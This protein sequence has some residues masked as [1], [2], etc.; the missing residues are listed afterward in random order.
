MMVGLS[1][2]IAGPS[3]QP[4]APPAPAF[5]QIAGTAPAT[6][7]TNGLEPLSP[8][9]VIYSP[10]VTSAY[11][12]GPG[13]SISIAVTPQDR[14]SLGTVSI[15]QDGTI[16]Y[17][18]LGTIHVAGKTVGDLKVELEG[19]LSVYCVNPDVTVQVTALR[20]EPVYV[21]GG[22]A[23][24]RILDVRA[25]GTVA[26]AVT[27][28]GGA[29]DINMLQRVTIFRGNQTLH[30]DVYQ[31]LIDGVD[32]GD[33]IA[34]EPDDLVVVPINTARI[35]VLGAVNNPGVYSLAAS[36]GNEGSMHLSDALS[37]AGGTSRE[38]ARVHEIRLIR[39]GPDGKPVMIAY[40]Y[41][42][43]MQSG[44]LT[45]NPVLQDKDMIV[46]PDSKH[47]TQTG[48]LFPY[49]SLFGFFRAL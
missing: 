5:G 25:A 18:R 30:A 44:D 41:G 12:L 10:D 13:D 32:N 2:A 9:S 31:V 6:D 20:P 37:Q 16:M 8:N 19:K 47:I 24:P 4:S 46:V 28:A 34:L 29:T 43:F 15:P 45:Q 17:P 1:A 21:T 48:D 42:K 14:Y 22:V 40:D 3:S 33:N 35:E 27:L 23:S 39:L 26:K 38:G 11:V 7:L 49:L 36:S